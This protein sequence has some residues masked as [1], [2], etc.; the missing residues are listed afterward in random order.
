[1]AKLTATAVRA[2]Q[3]GR[4]HDGDGLYL[5]VQPGGGRSWLLGVQVDGR[6]RDIGLGAADLSPRAAGKGEASPIDIP[7]LQRKL[8]TLA[9]AREK[10]RMLREAAKAGLDP[11]LDRDRE[12]R[13]IPTFRDAP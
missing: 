6:R 11:I 7:L 9:E 13:S 1:M 8:L 3:P 2:A 5:N 12:R 4:H 10:A